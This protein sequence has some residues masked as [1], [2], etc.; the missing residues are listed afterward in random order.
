[1]PRTPNREECFFSIEDA[2]KTRYPHTEE[3][4]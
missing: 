2:E 3:L 4:K 1:M